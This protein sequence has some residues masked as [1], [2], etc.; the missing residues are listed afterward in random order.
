ML[1]SRSVSSKTYE[2]QNIEHV[3]GDSRSNEQP[4]L[5]VF[6]TVWMREHNRL[7][8]ELTYLNPH[9]DDERIYQETRKIVIAEMQVRREVLV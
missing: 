6:H 1:Q 3:A 4:G 2:I 9:W 8:K 7:A 5:T